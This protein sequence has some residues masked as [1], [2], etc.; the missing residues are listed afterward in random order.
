MTLV[1]GGVQKAIQKVQVSSYLSDPK[2]AVTV[3]VQFS[4]LQAGLNHVAS[5]EINGVS[6]QM[7][8]AVK[9]FNYQIS[10]M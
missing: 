4:R 5:T 6:K 1:F 10:Q 7:T 8:V 9:N 2:D 3:A